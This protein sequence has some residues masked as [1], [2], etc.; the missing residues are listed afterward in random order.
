[1]VRRQRSWMARPF[2]P[3]QRE[4]EANAFA[5]SILIPPS[6]QEELMRQRPRVDAVVRF[7]VSAG[8]SPDIVVGQMQHLGLIGLNQ[9]NSL[10][11]RYTW[12]DIE[13]VL[14]RP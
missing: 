8:V 10:K 2:S 4:D 14:P 3:D 6:R 5:A 1:M 13:A 11:R 9:L 12:A 7:A